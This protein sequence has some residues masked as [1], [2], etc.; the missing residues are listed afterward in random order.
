M[1]KDAEHHI[2]CAVVR[3]FDLQYPQYRGRLFAVPNG[4][5]RHIAVASKL[6]AEGVRRGVPDLHLPV[7]TADFSGLVIEMK[8]K[9]GKPTPEQTDWLNFYA[10]QGFMAVLCVGIDSALSTIKQYLEGN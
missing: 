4:G 10:Q 1:S 8:A 5:V 7:K 3:W 6:K 2:Q 9:G